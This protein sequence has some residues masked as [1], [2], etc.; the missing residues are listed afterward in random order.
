MRE[1]AEDYADEQH[2][3]VFN[4]FRHYDEVV[5]YIKSIQSATKSLS[6]EELLEESLIKIF[7]FYQ[8]QPHLLDPYLERLIADCLSV[9]HSSS[10]DQRSLHFAFRVLYLMVKTRGYKSIVRL[11]P[12]T[13]DDI[14]P[15]LSLL[16]AQ[17]ISDAQ[18]WQTRYVLLLWLSILIMVPFGLDCLDSSDK[19]PIA[20][21]II[22]QCERYLSHDERTQEAASFLLARLVT[23]P[24][25]VGTH[26]TPIVSWCTEQI[27]AADYSTSR[28]QCLVCGVL[29]TLANI[30]KIGRRKEML[31]HASDLLHTI[32]QMPE[33]SNKGIPTC[34]METKLIQRIGLL[35][36][37]PRV[38][39]WQYHRGC[40]SLA[41]N[42]SSQ[43]QGRGDTKSG[44]DETKKTVLE[45]GEVDTHQMDSETQQSGE[46][47]FDLS[48][49]D[50]VAEVIDY[51][52]GA[53]RSQYTVVRWSAAKGLGRMC[54]RLTLSMVTDVLS[55][56]LVLCTRLEPFTAWHGACLALAELGRRSLLLPSKLSEVI[57]VVLRA[58]FY[59]ERSGD[60]S[61]GSNV[62]DA[63]CYVC[64]A[65]A[66][67]YR[68]EDFAPY[69]T[70]V[71]NALVLVSLFD[72]EVNVRRAGAAAFQENV[73]RQGQF[74]HGI[75]ILTACDYFAVRNRKNCYLKL[76]AF[77]AQF[78]EYAKPM[79]DHLANQLLGH[80][81]PAIRVL[82]SQ[83]LSVLC[84]SD[85]EYMLKTILPQLVRS[86]TESALFTRQGNIFGTAELIFALR[87]E[88]IGAD[89]LQGIKCIVPTLLS[90]KQFFG[91]SGELLRKAVCHLI[92][93]S[94]AAN[95]PIHQDPIIETWRIF[96]DDCLAQRDPEVQKSAVTAY[97]HFLS[98]YLYGEDGK[99]QVDYRD[100]IFGH[101]LGQLDVS[102]EATLSG[103]LLVLADAPVE[104]FV[105]NANRTLENIMVACRIT[106]RT[107]TWGDARRS[108]LKALTGVFMHLGA[109]CPEIDS[110]LRKQIGPVLLRSLS[111]YTVDS[112]GDIGSHVRE[113][114]IICL[115]Q[116][117]DFLVVSDCA[118]LIE[119]ELFEEIL[120]SIVQQA[121]EKI[122][123]TRGVA[124]QAFSFLLHHEPPIPNFPHIE[125]LKRIFPK[126][127]CD[128]L[129][130]SAAH[131]TFPR[132]TRLL[133]FP[134]FRFRLILG[135]TVS[136]GGLTEQT[137]ICSQKA[138]SSFLQAHEEDHE[139]LI[140]FMRAVEQVFDSYARE[141][142]VILPLLKFLDFLLN[143]PAMSCALEDNP[144]MLLRLISKTWTETK[145]IKDVQRIKAAIDVLGAMTQFEGPPRKRASS[146]LMLLLCHRYPVIRKA[147]A[148]KIYELL[149]I[150]ELAESEKI[151][152]IVA[153]VTDTIWESDLKIIRPVRN[154]ICELLGLE[155][156]VLLSR[157]PPT[158]GTTTPAMNGSTTTSLTVVNG[159]TN[160][161]K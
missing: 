52:I 116:F 23:R 124:G 55:A 149:M 72:R 84:P 104:L 46:E 148:T 161:T 87:K 50:E 12:H 92:D 97:P 114:G 159:Q 105:G 21:R 111:D 45:N 145:T 36:C 156:P 95:L 28:G 133:D 14:E 10:D 15:T 2:S 68:A 71:A 110:S 118:D 103:Y 56:I 100:K 125:E 74:P 90:K 154:Q 69:V 91:L 7:N 153:L 85:T 89:D 75:D 57:P 119:P 102:S 152:K 79:I 115:K 17:D 27:R 48:N 122:D 136:V 126:A 130:W 9:V 22:V 40:R 129:M 5:K 1:D 134:V 106:P 65:F 20:E 18:T 146:L 113:D 73:G 139:I 81:D 39:T 42:L 24:D 109:K 64:W 86:S 96:L 11:M 135:L 59:D 131:Q 132:F 151:E 157:T 123:R 77:V 38:T 160:N 16:T 30:C 44:N 141:E 13:V 19:P 99:L 137:V 144:P 25:I 150:Y 98:T 128:S 53:L 88:S 4:E 43:L 8:E 93:K 117:L 158:D 107:R 33:D 82:A 61:Y 127:D 67:A 155:V 54:A 32:L 76:S 47:D 101:L 49:I 51:L 78:K 138:L 112:R 120:S 70:Q 6:D 35:F 83:A 58:L 63:A 121:V 108:A 62:R 94:S 143:D 66:R 37:S 80:W 26:L 147:T 3:I 140:S 60:H 31:P 41:D 29:R 34:R 142:R